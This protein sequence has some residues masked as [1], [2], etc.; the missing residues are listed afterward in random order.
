MVQV[1]SGS[2]GVH[3]HCTDR[4]ATFR[5]V[6]PARSKSVRDTGGSDLHPRPPEEGPKTRF[7]S[8]ACPAPSRRRRR[9][10]ESGPAETT[11]PRPNSTPVAGRKRE[12]E[13][14]F[15]SAWAV[16]L[17][18]DRQLDRRAQGGYVQRADALA[19]TSM[20]VAGADFTASRC[21]L[22]PW[23]RRSNRS[24]IAS[25]MNR[26]RGENIWLSP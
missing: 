5:A 13:R 8:P 9:R 7:R 20:R 16:G 15:P 24:R 17:D 14:A 11:P 25:G 4:S 1:R 10:P 6:H 21:C 22:R 12:Q 19:R 2:G 23:V 26:D 18:S 3:I